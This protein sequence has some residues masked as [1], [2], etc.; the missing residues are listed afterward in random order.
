MEKEKIKKSITKTPKNLINLQE[1]HKIVKSINKGLI[2]G[3]EPDKLAE[4]L[5]DNFPN[6]RPKE[7]IDL[8]NTIK[9]AIKKNSD[10]NLTKQDLMHAEKIILNSLSKNPDS[11]TSELIKDVKVALSI[12]K[13]SEKIKSLIGRLRREYLVDFG[14]LGIDKRFKP[15]GKDFYVKEEKKGKFIA[16]APNNTRPNGY[17][18]GF[19][20]NKLFFLG[21]KEG[22]EK[23]DYTRN[24][25]K[26]NLLYGMLPGGKIIKKIDDNVICK[27]TPLEEVPDSLAEEIRKKFIKAKDNVI[28]GLSL[29]GHNVRK[30]NGKVDFETISFNEILDDLQSRIAIVGSP[31]SGKTVIANVI[32][33]QIMENEN[34]LK[35]GTVTI[36]K[37]VPNLTNVANNFNSFAKCVSDWDEDNS[38]AELIKKLK[39]EKFKHHKKIM[40]SNDSSIPD[41]NKLRKETLFALIR[42][43]EC[44]TQVKD[45]LRKCLEETKDVVETLRKAKEGKLLGEEYT[46]SQGTALKRLMN[47]IIPANYEEINKIDLKKELESN[48]H[49]SFFIKGL[50]SDVFGTMIMWELYSLQKSK[51]IVNPAVEGKLLTIDECQKFVRDN[52]F[53]DIYQRIVV[54]GRNFGVCMMSIFQNEKEAENNM[55][56]PDFITYRASLEDGKRIINAREKN[57]LIPTI[58]PEVT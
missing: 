33:R 51:E 44:S 42:N 8:I 2:L 46:R 29:A 16:V 32:Q 20:K 18:I 28:L 11:K 24:H 34:Y 3:K 21:H 15:K 58:A 35:G 45:A 25:Y 38:S 48:N 52:A 31:G 27:G 23:E 12:E 49:I 43:S 36:A 55:G 47:S 5:I 56:Y 1:E 26:I 14:S 37:D 30:I 39:L 9:K 10:E 57:A 4:E 13:C 17:V 54:D 22:I 50:N 7:L 53:K 19:S 40:I 6:I 41:L